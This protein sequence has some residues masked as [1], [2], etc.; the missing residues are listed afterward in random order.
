MKYIVKEEIINNRIDKVVPILNN[1][2]T[3]ANSQKLI[4]EGNI[5][6][7]GKKLNHHIK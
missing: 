4:E 3:R 7:N 2:I 6:V 5:V 1:E